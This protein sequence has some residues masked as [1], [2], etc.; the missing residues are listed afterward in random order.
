M[1]RKK[2]LQII[3]DA[4]GESDFRGYYEDLYLDEAAKAALEA[5]EKIGLLKDLEDE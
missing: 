1:T 5:I 3:E 4:I 2:L